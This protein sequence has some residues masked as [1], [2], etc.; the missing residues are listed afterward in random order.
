MDLIDRP[1]V[2]KILSFRDARF[3]YQYDQFEF[4]AKI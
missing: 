2:I 3:L 1:P 4:G